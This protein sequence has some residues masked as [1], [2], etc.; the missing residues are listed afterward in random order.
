MKTNLCVIISAFFLM[1]S[2]NTSGQGLLTNT[3]TYGNSDPDTVTYKLISRNKIRTITAYVSRGT[4]G[5]NNGNMFTRQSIEE[6]DENGYLKNRLYYLDDSSVSNENSISIDRKYD[7]QN[8]LIEFVRPLWEGDW[9]IKTVNY[10]YDNIGRIRRV[11]ISRKHNTSDLEK[12]FIEKDEISYD[13]Y[14]NGLMK[15]KEITKNSPESKETYNY[16]YLF[17]KDG[18]IKQAREIK[19]TKYDNDPATYFDTSITGYVR[20][21]DK[22]KSLIQISW[23]WVYNSLKNSEG[24]DYLDDKGR[25][26]KK[27]STGNIPIPEYKYYSSI[28]YN[29]YNDSIVVIYRIDENITGISTFDNQG[30]CLHSKTMSQNNSTLIKF[31]YGFY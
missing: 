31:E 30:L 11:I 29:Y 20:Q 16:D 19:K 5:E 12:K 9:M 28:E 15:E 17:Y 13:F 24:I 14:S 21:Y 2:F 7:E 4:I 1:V 3:D 22:K 18:N 26:I 27:S 8:R 10:E 6:F 25:I 23:E